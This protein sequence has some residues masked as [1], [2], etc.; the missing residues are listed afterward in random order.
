MLPRN[1]VEARLDI[2]QQFLTPEFL[3]SLEEEEDECTDTTK[4]NEPN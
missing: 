4:G 2:I 1:E 3:K